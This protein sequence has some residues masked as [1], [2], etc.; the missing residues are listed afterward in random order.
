L[1]WG[2]V[3]G[4]GAREGGVEGGVEGGGLEISPF[5]L[6]VTTLPIVSPRDL[7]ERK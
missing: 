6:N 5:R 1:V 3:G 7:S 2:G 4:G